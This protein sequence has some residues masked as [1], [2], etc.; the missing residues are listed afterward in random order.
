MNLD[1]ANQ[2]DAYQLVDYFYQRGWLFPGSKVYPYL[3]AIG[4]YS[5]ACKSVE[6]TAV[7]LT[8]FDRMNN[9]FRQH[10]SKYIDARQV[11]WANYPRSLTLNCSAVARHSVIF[12]PDGEMY[13]CPRDLGM[14]TNSHGHLAGTSRE[15]S[16][17]FPI[18]SDSADTS[19]SCS[20]RHDYASYDPF[21][22]L[23][24]LQCRY[25]PT[26]LGGC[27]KVQLEKQEYYLDSVCRYSE[28]SFEPMIR[29]FADSIVVGWNSD[30]QERGTEIKRESRGAPTTGGCKRTYA[31]I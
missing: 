25:L 30:P 11:A 2:E 12:G 26:C 22:N 16:D 17:L 13:K 14:R 4:P 8:E 28:H 15:S 9:A 24:C 7:E 19:W 1:K 23:L 3:A 29:N 31:R 5:E 18:L 21:S 6:R 10:V 27:R 20:K